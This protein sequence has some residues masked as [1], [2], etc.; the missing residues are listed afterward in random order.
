MLV[1]NEIFHSIQGESSYAGRPCVFIRLTGCNLRCRYCDTVYAYDDGVSMSVEEILQNVHRFQCGL[2]EIT[3][4]E[5][6]LQDETPRLAAALL[7]E[8]KTVLVET[9][10]SMDIDVLPEKTIRI[11]DIKC[12]SSGESEKMDWDNL[13]RLNSKDEVKFVVADQNDFDWAVG[14]VRDY[15]LE[16]VCVVLFSPVTEQLPASFLAN[17]ILESELDVRFQLQLHKILWLDQRG[18]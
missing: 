7:N 5:P 18:K 16:S 8:G 4:G 15:H 11:M 2:V 14:I 9:N 12:P 13:S 3:G 6:L 10:G 17:W 1:V